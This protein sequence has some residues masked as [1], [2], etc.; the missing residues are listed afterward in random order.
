MK[1]WWPN[2]T[3]M[4]K[5]FLRVQKN[6]NLIMSRT[7]MWKFLTSIPWAHLINRHSVSDTH[8]TIN[9]L[10]KVVVMEQLIFSI[11]LL[12][13]N[14]SFWTKI[15][16]SQCRVLRSD[17]AQLLVWLWPRMSLLPSMLM[18][19][20]PII[21]LPQVRSC[22]PYIQELVTNCLHVI[23]TQMVLSL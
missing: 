7:Q 1:L 4:M 21:I 2:K 19:V 8:Q 23:I 12:V 6:F 11:L 22:I 16:T 20:Y 9:I 14:H 17:G 15:W 10:L 5:I 3:R 18:V 13:S